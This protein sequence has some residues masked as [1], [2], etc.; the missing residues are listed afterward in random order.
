MGKLLIERVR[1]FTR[2][3]VKIVNR[4]KLEEYCWVIP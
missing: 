2:G 4:K 3:T 1:E